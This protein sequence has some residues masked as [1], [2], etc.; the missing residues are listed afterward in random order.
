MRKKRKGKRKKGKLAKFKS[1][2]YESMRYLRS[3]LRY[4]LFVFVLFVIGGVVGVVFS[5]RVNEMLKIEELLRGLAEKVMGMNISELIFFIFQN[6][7]QSAFLGLVLGIVLGIFPVINALGN[8]MVLGYVMK[9][10]WR[11]SGVS[12]FWRLLPHGVFELVAVF[13]ALGLGVKLGVSLFSKKGR[14]EIN[15]RLLWSLIIFVCV[16]I[17]LLILAAVIEGILIGVYK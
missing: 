13:I 5:E 15:K 14:K 7:V 8:G 11:I 10:S 17:P 2:F 6:N 12:D 16:V 4:V 3:S 9:A 1:Y